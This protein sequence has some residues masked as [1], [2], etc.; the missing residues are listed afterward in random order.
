MKPSEVAADVIVFVFFLFVSTAGS[1]QKQV[2][3]GS[4]NPRP[5]EVKLLTD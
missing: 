2:C 3:C 5:V 4:G 1:C